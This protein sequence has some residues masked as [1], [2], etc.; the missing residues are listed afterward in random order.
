MRVSQTMSANP[1]RSRPTKVSPQCAYA[2]SER[3]EADSH[4]TPLQNQPK[5]GGIVQLPFRRTRDRVTDLPQGKVLSRPS[6][7]TAI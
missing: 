6:V 7:S 2:W 4:L 5:F 1:P 3:F